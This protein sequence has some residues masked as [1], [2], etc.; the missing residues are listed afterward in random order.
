MSNDPR[1]REVL[2]WE[3]RRLSTPKRPHARYSNPYPPFRKPEDLPPAVKRAA[4]LGSQTPTTRQTLL[5]LS[6]DHTPRQA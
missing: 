1:G 4:L 3:L 5:F 6:L 2:I